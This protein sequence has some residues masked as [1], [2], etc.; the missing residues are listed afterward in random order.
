MCLNEK[1]SSPAVHICRVFYPA[2]L[3]LLLA[4]IS[5]VP[6][7]GV[8][9]S[10]ARAWNEQLLDAIRKDVPNPPVHAR[11]L[12]HLSAITYDIWA[13]YD[14]TAVGYLVREKRNP[15]N[16]EIERTKAI[17]RASYQFLLKRYRT[18]VGYIRIRADLEDL[19]NH[20]GL[21]LFYSENLA[22]EEEKFAMHVMETYLDFFKEDGSYENGDG[23]I[24]WAFDLPWDF[25]YHDSSYQSANEPYLLTEPFSLMADPNRWQ[26]LAFDTRVTQNGLEVSSLQTF[27]GAQWGQVIPFS[28]EDYDMTNGVYFDPGTPP[29]LEGTADALY[30]SEFADV[31]RHSSLLDVNNP[32]LVDIS[33]AGYGNNTLGTNNGK[34][35]Q[36]NPHTG[37]PYESNYVPHS[38]FGR[39]LAEFWADGPDSETPPGHWNTLANYASEHPATIKK[40]GGVGD[41]IDDLE[42][43]VKLYF[44]LNGAV[45][46]AAVTAWGCKRFYDYVRPITAI[47]HMGLLGQSSDPALPSYHP[48]GLP[49][50]DGLIELVTSESSQEGERHHTFQNQVGKVVMNAWTAANEGKGISESGV[51]WISPTDW[52]PYQRATFVTPAFPG[53]VSGHSVFSRSAAEVLAE[54]TGSPYFPGGMG[55]FTAKANEFLQFD[56]GPSVDVVLQWATYFDAADQAGLSRLYGGIHPS[57]DD[58]PGRIMGSKCGKKAISL[59]LDYYDGTIVNKALD[60][61]ENLRIAALPDGS[62]RVT[63]DSVRGFE[64]QLLYSSSLN[65]FTSHLDPIVAEGDSVTLL[66]PSVPGVEYGFYKVTA[67]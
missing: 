23:I 59:A 32:E 66:V 58:F 60:R 57:V 22:S 19:M 31:V 36:M 53:Y 34:G 9:K 33:P 67:R 49:L 4:L 27:L 48:N 47:K 3:G 55:S 7:I 42:W 64:Y 38:D 45:H 26:P 14:S 39:V 6:E 52:M 5:L 20:L 41:V 65:N 16:L 30:K 8:G 2:V 43:D 63:F 35:Y 61:I 46:D 12:F 28:L 15:E 21:P 11:N 54:Y 10:I 13:A 17:S 40:I 1:I 51:R 24:D 62:C 29:Q 18:S 37:L 56:E 50:I 25:T 44:A